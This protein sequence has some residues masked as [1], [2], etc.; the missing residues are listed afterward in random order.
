M[1]IV[2]KQ[3][4]TDSPVNQPV[5]FTEGL[6]DDERQALE[7]IVRAYPEK[8]LDDYT[9]ATQVYNSIFFEDETPEFRRAVC[10]LLCSL[11]PKFQNNF[12][13]KY[14]N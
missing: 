13:I 10:K 5:L 1:A 14:A 9:Q 11:F 8:S 4:A 6:T 7:S 3:V 12:W 2:T